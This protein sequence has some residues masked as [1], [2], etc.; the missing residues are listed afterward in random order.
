MHS[1]VSFSANKRNRS[2][3]G[4]TSLIDVVFI[5]LLFFMLSSTFSPLSALDI[6]SAANGAEQ[7]QSD[8]KPLVIRVINAE[9]WRI[10]QTL[11]SYAD[12]SSNQSLQQA[13]KQNAPVLVHADANASV[14][15]VVS[16]LSFLEQQGVTNLNLGESTVSSH[17]E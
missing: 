8:T 7:P 14:Q 9:Q 4:L 6:S 13:I 12:N 3:I 17:A 16:A 11:H 1:S 2:P 15:H 5:L 10:G